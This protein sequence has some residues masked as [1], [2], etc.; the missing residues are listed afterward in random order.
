M[1][2]F[3]IHKGITA[4]LL[5]NNIDTDTIIPSYEM[6]KVSKVGLSDGLFAA[7]RYTKANSR[8]INPEFILNKPEYKNT[9]ILLCGDNFGCGSSRE[10][11][12][13]ALKEYGIRCIIAPSF[14]SIFFMNC[15][16]NG[17]LPIR[18]NAKKIIEINNWVK[19]SPQNNQ[20]EINLEQQLISFEKDIQYE[21]VATVADKNMLINGLDS[22][23]LTLKLSDNIQNFEVED[24]KRRPWV[25]L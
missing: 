23:A 17:I 2:K 25:Y 9:S 1:E 15:V 12:V 21:F 7:S 24:K 4:A 13:W 5:R 3:T 11:A 19:Q 6:K 16:R 14:G 20:V 22:I 10:H 18:L 8:Q